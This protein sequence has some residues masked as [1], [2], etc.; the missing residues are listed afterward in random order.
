MIRIVIA[1]DEQRVA[2]FIAR[3]YPRLVHHHGRCRRCFASY[4]PMTPTSRSSC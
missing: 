2:S 4:A 1:E 3:A